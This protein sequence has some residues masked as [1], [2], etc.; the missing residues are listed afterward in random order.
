MI[1]QKT[2]QGKMGESAT[3]SPAV[4]ASGRAGRWGILLVLVITFAV[5]APTL[6]YQFVHDDRGQIVENPAVRSWHA[7]PTYFTAHAWAG[8]MPDEW[9]NY[10]RPI[11]LLWLRLNDAVF[12]NQAWGW[13]L[14]NILA[15][16]LTTL[17]VYLLVCRL[18]IGDDVGLLAAL[19]F[20]LHP[21]HIEGVAWI[22]G[23]TEPLLGVFLI[24]SLLAY[25]QSREEGPGTFRWK[26]VS[27]LLFVLAMLEKETGLILP[28]LMVIYEWIYGT[29]WGDRK[30]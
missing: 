20:G 22:S 23:V 14:T 15:H 8:V 17:L 18:G 27:L 5:Y 24:A 7:V 16:V 30:S 25:V 19:I 2:S 9:V 26:F 4:A 6:R 1:K 10:Y 29:E 13:H 12:G 21:A 28:G 11:F 3:Q